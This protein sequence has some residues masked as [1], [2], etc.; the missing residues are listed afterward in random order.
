MPPGL[1]DLF[2]RLNR[3][4]EEGSQLIRRRSK[5]S[6]KSIPTTTPGSTRKCA[7]MQ[8]AG[9]TPSGLRRSGGRVAANARRLATLST[10][11]HARLVR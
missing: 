6:T 9:T 7:G 3:L 8:R 2:Q 10:A 11:R 5:V 1:Y 4:G